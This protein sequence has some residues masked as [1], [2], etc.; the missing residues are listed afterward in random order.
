[1]NVI[2][3]S[4]III[5]YNTKMLTIECIKSIIRETNGL[6][7]EII[8]VDNNSCD[9]SVIEIKNVFREIKIISLNKNIGFATANNLASEKTKGKYILLLNPDTIILKGAIQKIFNYAENHFD[10]GIYG[11]KTLSVDG[12]LNPISCRKKPN[13]WSMFCLATGLSALFKNKSVIFDNESYGSWKRD[14]EKCV[15]IVSGCFMLIRKDIWIKMK[16]FDIR[17]FMY[18]EEVDFCL[19]AKKNGYRT[20]FTPDPVIIHY[21]GAS[22][23]KQ[24]DKMIMLLNA[25]A[26]N[27]IKHWK[28]GT[29]KIGLL[30]LKLWIIRRI[31]LNYIKTLNNNKN[32]INLI[33]IIKVW[34]LRRKWAKGYIANNNQ[35]SFE[36]YIKK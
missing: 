1:M 2:N 17:Y 14:T 8:V 20:Y 12:K 5:N 4:I 18:G 19:R 30:L 33:E 25:K 35:I 21:E 24:A 13:V 3:I 27:I 31:I 29:V 10:I 22:N 16:G 11:G 7:Y 9:G 15:D 36:K 6:N 23:Q 34:E 26:T 32:K 28:K